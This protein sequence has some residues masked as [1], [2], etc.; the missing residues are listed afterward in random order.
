MV[1]KGNGW[2]LGSNGSV[3]ASVPYERNTDSMTGQLHASADVFGHTGG[4]Y[5]FLDANKRQWGLELKAA[6]T[7]EDSWLPVIFSATSV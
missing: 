1:E 2:L 4:P 3:I 5:S 7:K 6:P